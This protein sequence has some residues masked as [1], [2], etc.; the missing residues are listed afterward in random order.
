MKGPVH[1]LVRVGSLLAVTLACVWLGGLLTFVG[2]VRALKPPESPMADGIVVLTGGADRLNAA[3][4]LLQRGQAKRLLISGVHPETRPEDLSGVTIGTKTL[5]ECCVDLGREARNTRG[6]ALE[7][8]K[9][10]N[11]HDY[12]R[13]IVVTANYH[14]PRTLL[15]F[16][17]ALPAAVLIA[18]PV[19]PREVV[20]ERWWMHPGTTGL[21]ASEYT[22]YLLSLARIGPAIG[23]A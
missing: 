2:K 16:H 9:W 10:A 17:K 4:A 18:Y 6:N 22:K 23:L 3:I 19:S 20:L 15:E 7:A 8:A 14:T 11:A 1:R 21:L 12:R 13:L 5:F